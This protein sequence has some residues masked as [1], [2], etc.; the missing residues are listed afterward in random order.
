MRS[1]PHAA[2]RSPKL[3]YMMLGLF[4]RIALRF[5]YFR[6]PLILKRVGMRGFVFGWRSVG[7]EESK[8]V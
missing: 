3:P 1:Q 8:R 7:R 2:T 6:R 4:P 5:R